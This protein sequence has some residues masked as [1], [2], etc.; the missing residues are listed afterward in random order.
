[1]KTASLYSGL[2][3]VAQ[4]YFQES[5]EQLGSEI[6]KKSLLYFP[7]SVTYTFIYFDFSFLGTSVMYLCGRCVMYLQSRLLCVKAQHVDTAAKLF[8]LHKSPTS[9][10]TA[11]LPRSSSQDYMDMWRSYR[12]R[13]FSHQSSRDSTLSSTEE[14]NPEH[15]LVPIKIS[16][17]H[18]V[19]SGAG[20]V[21]G[22][23]ISISMQLFILLL[24]HF[25]TLRSISPR[26]LVMFPLIS[27]FLHSFVHLL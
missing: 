22:E 15:G 13:N 3:A 12:I 11:M 16:E 8:T 21:P 20:P 25:L 14:K 23:H 6:N 5:A 17:L 27:N 24:F 4:C 18:Q 10:P 26:A 7:L 19:S 9:I 2:K 1:M